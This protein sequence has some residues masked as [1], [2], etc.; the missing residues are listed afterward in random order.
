MADLELLARE[1]AV[2]FITEDP[3]FRNC[4]GW[5]PDLTDKR[6][7]Y[8]L[9]YIQPRAFL[10]IV[11]CGPGFRPDKPSIEFMVEAIRQGRCFAPS[12]LWPL[13]QITNIAYDFRGNRVWLMNHEGRH[14]AYVAAKLGI[15]RIPVA[16]WRTKGVYG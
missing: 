8:D 12:Q 7:K 16:I 3:A 2:N 14:R 13:A 10:R 15:P 4:I 1:Y 5:T 11:H 9:V 6:N